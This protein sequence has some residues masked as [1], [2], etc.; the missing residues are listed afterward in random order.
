MT[1]EKASPHT[2]VC[3]RE[4]SQLSSD[5]RQRELIRTRCARSIVRAQHSRALTLAR[6]AS[7]SERVELIAEAHRLIK[8]SV[9]LAAE[10]AAL[11]ALETARGA[12]SEQDC[13]REAGVHRRH[14]LRAA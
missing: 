6:T 8:L 3:P 13:V 10:A 14:G 2:T 12:P 9:A 4:I 7:A 1:A 11:Q 5:E